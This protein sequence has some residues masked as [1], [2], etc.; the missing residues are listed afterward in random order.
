MRGSGPN[1]R[2]VV[3]D[4]EEYLASGK[5]AAAAPAAAAPKAAAAPSAV[6]SGTAYT[7]IP[8]NNIRKITAARLLESKQNIPHYYLTMEVNM[9]KL[10]E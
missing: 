6:S 7:D 9:D 4:V 2:I 10:T 8:N 3:A 1:G 5:K